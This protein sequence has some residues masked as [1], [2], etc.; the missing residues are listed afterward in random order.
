M[1]TIKPTIKKW[2]QVKPKSAKVCPPY[3]LPPHTHTMGG[4]STCVALP[5]K[6]VPSV[7]RH[8]FEDSSLLKL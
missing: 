5:R 7:L 1:A 6:G 2:N 3:P 8:P 4:D